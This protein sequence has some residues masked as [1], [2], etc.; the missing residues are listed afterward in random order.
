[1]PLLKSGEGGAASFDFYEVVYVPLCRS[2]CSRLGQAITPSTMMLNVW[3]DDA[4]DARAGIVMAGTEGLYGYQRQLPGH[5][6]VWNHDIRQWRD[7]FAVPISSVAILVTAAS[8][9]SPIWPASELW[10]QCDTRCDEIVASLAR[11][12]LFLLK[13]PAPRCLAAGWHG[14]AALQAMHRCKG[15]HNYA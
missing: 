1:M 6:C 14:G 2:G 9:N 4:N 15:S 13:L 3:H 5:K 7:L 10:L 12:G 8:L 11:N